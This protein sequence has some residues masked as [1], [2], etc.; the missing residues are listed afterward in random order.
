MPSTNNTCRQKPI[1]FH[2]TVP[3][4]A[5]KWWKDS[6]L[7]YV[8]VCRS[9]MADFLSILVEY[10]DRKEN[11]EQIRTWLEVPRPKTLAEI[12]WESLMR[13]LPLPW[14]LPPS[15]SEHQHPPW[16]YRITRLFQSIQQMCVV[17]LEGKGCIASSWSGKRVTSSKWQGWAEWPYSSMPEQETKCEIFDHSDFHD[18]SLSMGEGAPLGLKYS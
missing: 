18:F 6:R 10:S 17:K 12:V 4:S 2:E 7:K 15:S 1:P 9:W 3:F 14:S 8:Q 11:S 16:W 5:Y 13:P